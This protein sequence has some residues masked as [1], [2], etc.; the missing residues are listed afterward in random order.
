MR[1]FQFIGPEYGI[2]AIKDQRLKISRIDQLNDPFEM[3]AGTQS[4]R[5]TRFAMDV[6]RKSVAS[7]L[8]VLCFS[9]DWHNPVM[10]SH[11]AD[12]HR[13]LCLG[14]DVDEA[15]AMPV[16]YVSRRVEFD[17]YLDP[18][19]SESEVRALASRFAATK[20]SHWRYEKEVRCWASLDPDGPDLQ[21][22]HFD[23]HIKLRQVCI[24]F[25][26]SM[27]RRMVFDALGD[28]MASTVSVMSTRLAY[29]TFRVVTQ[30]NKKL[31][32]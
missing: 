18:A 25:Q 6:I 17:Q 12:N 2:Q 26:S 28:E 32:K 3:F 19:T 13:G 9:R 27:T 4:D 7:R 24:G 21:F 29:R 5:R 30:Q 31:W 16:D 8:G 20:Y 1:L 23:K 14:F 22:H 15:V 10:W 11:Y